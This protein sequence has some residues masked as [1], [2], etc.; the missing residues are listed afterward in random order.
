MRRLAAAIEGR[1][2]QPNFIQRAYRTTA[3][4]SIIVALA[5]LGYFGWESAASYALGALLGIGLMWALERTVD[6]SIRRMQARQDENTGGEP[7]APPTGSGGAVIAGINVLKYAVVAAVLYLAIAYGSVRLA[8]LLAGYGTIYVVI[9]L[10][11]VGRLMIG[12]P[13]EG[14]AVATADTSS[15]PSR[16]Q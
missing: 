10:K 12:P 8:F 3:V 14:D 6:A 15:G 5:V 11:A 1:H 2:S 4:S 9:V 7:A 16:G 13:T